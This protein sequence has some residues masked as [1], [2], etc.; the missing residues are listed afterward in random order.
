V[1]RTDVEGH[2]IELMVKNSTG[3]FSKCRV[4]MGQLRLDLAQFDDVTKATTEW[5]DNCL[6]L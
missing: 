1:G 2:T 5:Y 6:F 4:H 3:V